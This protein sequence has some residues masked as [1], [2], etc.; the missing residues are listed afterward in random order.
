MPNFID[1]LLLR[2]E[3]LENLTRH[4]L[5]AQNNFMREAKV[6]ASYEDGT[7][8]VKMQGLDSDRLP[9]LTR[10]GAIT[11]WAPL[12]KGERVL[13]LNP[14]GE[15]GRGLVLPGGYTDEFLQPHDQ[16]GQWFKGVGDTSMK[17]S[18]EEMIIS[19][20]TIRLV[21][22]VKVNG[23]SLTHNDKNVGHDHQHQ[24]IEPGNQNTG[25]PA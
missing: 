8:E 19:A 14:T 23:E 13:V 3:R 11:E 18:D 1:E 7:V 22:D 20:S 15:P 4:L 6:T 25:P 10:A 21:G 2:L 17:M 16:L 5:R 12:S 9:Q 24:G